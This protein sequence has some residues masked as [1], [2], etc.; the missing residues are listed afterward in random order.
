MKKYM[1]IIFLA[2]YFSKKIHLVSFSK[3]FLLLW[4]IEKFNLN[5]PIALDNRDNNIKIKINLFIYYSIP[6]FAQL[7]IVLEKWLKITLTNKLSSK[8]RQRSK[9]WHILRRFFQ[10]RIIERT[11]FLNGSTRFANNPWNILLSNK[12]HTNICWIAWSCRVREQ[13]HVQ[14]RV[15]SGM[16]WLTE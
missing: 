6:S 7:K 2:N 10:G 8:M 9:L 14:R 4:V 3:Q 13:E 15:V 12:N 11:W 16:E 1:Q 5:Y